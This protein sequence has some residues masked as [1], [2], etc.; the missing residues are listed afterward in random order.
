[1]DKFRTM[2]KAQSGISTAV[3]TFCILFYVFYYI[4]YSNPI[5]NITIAITDYYYYCYY[6]LLLLLLLLVLLL[7]LLLLLLLRLTTTT[8]TATT[9]SKTTATTLLLYG[10]LHTFSLSFHAINYQCHH[11]HRDFQG[12]Q[13]DELRH[14]PKWFQMDMKKNAKYSKAFTEMV[15]DGHEEEC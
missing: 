11:T 1:M 2:K 12:T 8:T 14:L 15:S 6:G 3:A 9:T 10:I 7:L 5:P 4:L 13:N